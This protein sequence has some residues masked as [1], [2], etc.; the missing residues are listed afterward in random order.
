M[1]DTFNTFDGGIGKDTLLG[2]TNADVMHGIAGADTLI[3]NGGDDQLWSG[4][5]T[6]P[7]GKNDRDGDLLDGGTGNDTINGGSGNDM[8]IGGAGTNTLN[9]NAGLDTALYNLA[10][11][12][13]TIA[14]KNGTIG[15]TSSTG[16]IDTLTSVERLHFTDV[17]VAYDIAGTAGQ[18]FRIYQ[19]ALNRAPDKGGLGFWINA[20]DH[21]ASMETVA[22]GFTHSAEWNS[23]YGANSSTETFLTALY[24][25]ALHR[26]PD[27]T[28][29]QFWTNELQH[30]S[31]RE[32]LLVR[33]AES[34][35]N[36]A[37]VIGSI[38]NGIEYTPYA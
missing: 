32:Y 22:A 28:G 2:T 20:A 3:G 30:G 9:G 36:Q 8:L 16:G 38:Q 6:D 31:S 5:A 21:G 19:A 15:I 34:A 27:P 18:V 25:N 1:A 14:Q 17:D 13:Y 4:S 11:G 12:D 10:R 26:E 33:F 23:L 29:M 37:Q 7:E 24:R 35:E